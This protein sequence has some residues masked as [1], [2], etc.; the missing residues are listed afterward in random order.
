MRVSEFSPNF[1]VVVGDRGMSG[2]IFPAYVAYR[3]SIFDHHPGFPW[4]LSFRLA[5][6]AQR[7]H[8]NVLRVTH[9]MV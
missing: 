8:C 6:A 9:I 5:A 1:S 7:S 4:L 2:S 3:G